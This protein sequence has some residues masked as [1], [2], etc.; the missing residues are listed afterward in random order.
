MHTG[1]F[2]KTKKGLNLTLGRI[3]A[4]E[5]EPTEPQLG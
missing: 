5:L 3:K 2:L 4:K 1:R